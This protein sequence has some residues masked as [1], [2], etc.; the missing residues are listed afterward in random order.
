MIWF[1]TVI[2]VCFCGNRDILVPSHQCHCRQTQPCLVSVSCF[3]TLD[4]SF[5]QS[6]VI[7]ETE[8]AALE[9]EAIQVLRRWKQINY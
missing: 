3:A 1:C 9:N 7:P 8:H 4:L 6:P 2:P 5:L